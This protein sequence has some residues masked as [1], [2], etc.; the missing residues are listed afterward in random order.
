MARATAI[1]GAT[2]DAAML[3]RALQPELT[4]RLRWVHTLA[5]GVDSLPFDTLRTRREHE[6]LGEGR[7]LTV[8]HHRGIS[9]APLAEFAMLGFMHFAK[10][11]P[12]AQPA[13]D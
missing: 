5:A 3:R 6:R 11:V 9:S 8:T 10:H 2:R 4:P 12:G 1:V 13:A 7:V